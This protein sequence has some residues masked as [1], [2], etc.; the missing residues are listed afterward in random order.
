MRPTLTLLTAMLIVAAMPA[1]ADAAGTA[2]PPSAGLQASGAERGREADLVEELAGDAQGRGEYVY[3][4]RR[5]ARQREIPAEKDQAQEFHKAYV[6][7]DIADTRM[8]SWE[9]CTPDYVMG[10]LIID[11]TLELTDS[12]VNEELHE[13]GYPALTAQNRYHAIQFAT[14][15]DARVVPRP[16]LVPGWR[17]GRP[18][19]MRY[20]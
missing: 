13:E 15:V 2:Q 18:T 7:F 10:A 11:P 5:M 12:S 4:A 3:V 14:G 6:A 8:L 19:T 16:I 9:F 17:Q 20:I 1:A